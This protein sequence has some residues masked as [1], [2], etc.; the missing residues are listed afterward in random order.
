[1]IVRTPCRTQL[2][3]SSLFALSHLFLEHHVP[4]AHFYP[5]R[6]HAALG[7][8][9][10]D[11]DFIDGWSAQRAIDTRERQPDMLPLCSAVWWVLSRRFLER[12]KCS[13]MNIWLKRGVRDSER[14]RCLQ[15]LGG[16]LKHTLLTH[17]ATLEVEHM[18][19]FEL[20]FDVLDGG[21]GGSDHTSA[22]RLASA[23]LA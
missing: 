10:E 12:R 6:R 2:G 16:S 22:R 14:A 18:E 7:V 4:V 23:C 17:G 13:S 9:L 19:E 1:M 20:S 8:S 21:C 5:V 11:R 3:N 15:L